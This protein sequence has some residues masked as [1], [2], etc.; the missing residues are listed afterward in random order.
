MSWVTRGELL[1]AAAARCGGGWRVRE[2]GAGEG[3]AAL[4]KRCGGKGW[5]GGDGTDQRRRLGAAA[6]ARAAEGRG[7]TFYLIPCKLGRKGLH[8]S[9][10]L[11]DHAL[12]TY[13]STSAARS[14]PYPLY[15]ERIGRYR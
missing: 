5:G 9:I 10:I 6:A 14:Q 7:P 1:A 12:G 11:I 8:A 13:I 3:G 4:G 2:M 15:R